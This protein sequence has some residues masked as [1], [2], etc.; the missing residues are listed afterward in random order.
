MSSHARPAMSNCSPRNSTRVGCDKLVLSNPFILLSRRVIASVLPLTI[1]LAHLVSPRP[2]LAHLYSG[3]YLWLSLA[4]NGVLTVCFLALG[5]GAISIFHRMCYEHLRPNIPKALYVC[6]LRHP[7]P[8]DP[9]ESLLSLI[10]RR[11]HV[12]RAKRSGYD[13]ASIIIPNYRAPYPDPVVQ[14]SSLPPPS[15]PRRNLPSLS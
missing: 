14:L 7:L 6:T 2:A 11:Q 13:V 8:K 3:P 5:A 1:K 12:S 9:Q 10:P 4:V 15:D